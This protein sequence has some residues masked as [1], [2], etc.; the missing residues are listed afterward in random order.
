MFPW[1]FLSVSLASFLCF[2]GFFL[3]L[4]CLLFSVSLAFSIVFPCVFL[5]FGGQSVAEKTSDE[6]AADGGERLS[7]TLK[8]RLHR[9]F[10][11][12]QLNAIFFSK[13][14]RVNRSAI[15]ARVSAISPRYSTI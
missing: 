8:A 15:S 9:R 7:F 6:R 2:P 3:V 10:L 13:I 11:S 14:A 1:L 5:V 4:P 12:P